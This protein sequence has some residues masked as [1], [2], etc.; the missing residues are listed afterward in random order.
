MDK[1]AEE[2]GLSKGT[3]YL[4]FKNKESLF[5]SIIKERTNILFQR[6]ET[7]ISSG[8]PFQDRLEKLVASYLDFFQEN[9]SFFKIV[10]SEKSR[11]ILQD[12]SRFRKHVLQSFKDYTLILKN[13]I[14]E[15]QK[16]G[17]LREYPSLAFTKALKG[18]MDAFTFQWIFIGSNGSLT[19]E[20][21]HIV[22]LFL[23]GAGKISDRN[24]GIFNE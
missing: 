9:E 14:E 8:E 15:G 16:E 7:V 3:L 13:F 10:H 2:V 11:V 19:R 20:T 6:L 18:L 21:A 5:F 1:I 24:G 12:R 22:D 4:Y 23:H 17:V